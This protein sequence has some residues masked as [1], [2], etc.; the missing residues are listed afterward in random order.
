[1]IVELQHYQVEQIYYDGAVAHKRPRAGEIQRQMKQVLGASCSPNV[2]V[3]TQYVPLISPMRDTRA[4]LR[5]DC[6]W[7][8]KEPGGKK[9]DT[10]SF[11][12]DIGE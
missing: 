3:E 7:V 10:V 12:D 1:M 6:Y 5:K 8:G 11:N 4:S 2:S 9:L